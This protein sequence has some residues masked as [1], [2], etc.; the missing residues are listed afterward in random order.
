MPSKSLRRCSRRHV[1]D[2]FKAAPVQFV[3]EK[4]RTVGAASE[5]DLAYSALRLRVEHARAEQTEGKSGPMTEER[6][7]VARRPC[8]NRELRREVR[9][10]AAAFFA[11]DDR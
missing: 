2:R 10:R 9:E 6:A 7:D 5:P 11:R 4:D 1:A 3:L 8:E